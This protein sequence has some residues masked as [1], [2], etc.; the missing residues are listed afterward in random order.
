MRCLGTNKDGRRCGWI[1]TA[2]HE[3]AQS[4]IYEGFCLWHLWQR[5]RSVTDRRAPSPPGCVRPSLETVDVETAFAAY[6]DMIHYL[7]IST[8]ARITVK[9]RT[10]SVE[11]YVDRFVKRHGKKIV[12]IDL[13]VGG[14]IVACR[15]GQGLLINIM[16]IVIYVCLTND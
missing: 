13:I 9:V 8:P 7:P 6:V 5:D 2:A 3:I 16:T 11:A 1:S 15:A 12:N 4:I 14:G 10:G